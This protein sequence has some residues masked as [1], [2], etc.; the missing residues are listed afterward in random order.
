MLV[1]ER[2]RKAERNWYLTW[3]QVGGYT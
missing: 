2:A 3:F 1:T